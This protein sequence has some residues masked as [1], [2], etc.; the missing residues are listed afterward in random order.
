MRRQRALPVLACVAY[1]AQV[2]PR[3][4]L[5]AMMPILRLF[6]LAA[7]LV[8]PTTA[9]GRDYDAQNFDPAS[10]HGIRDVLAWIDQ[11]TLTEGQRNALIAEG[12]IKG[13]DWIELKYNSWQ[14]RYEFESPT[15][16]MQSTLR[17]FY[18]AEDAAQHLQRVEA[19]L[20]ESVS[21]V[22]GSVER[23]GSPGTPG[24]TGAYFAVRN[25]A[26]EGV[27]SLLAQQDGRRLYIVEVG[28]FGAFEDIDQADEFLEPKATVALSFEPDLGGKTPAEA[29]IEP[30]F[31]LLQKASNALI[32]LLALL[33]WL[34]RGIVALVNRLLPDRVRSGRTAG[35]VAV[36]MSV[37][38][39]TIG[40]LW[41]VIVELGPTFRALPPLEQGR[42]SG[43]A[44]MVGFFPALIV[45]L[46]VGIAAW[47][48][49]TP[50]VEQRPM[51]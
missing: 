20:R 6:V 14:R 18:G 47:L 32:V 31:D 15:V 12:S 40:A 39:A 13:S 23:L 4:G 2:A 51:G 19:D 3:H 28:G 38:A 16:R 46:P 10:L 43:S 27:F 11:E 49:R 34:V 44:L 24:R 5:S 26:G 17:V 1:R 42:M 36:L 45:L 29:R 22:G 21:R 41:F 33:Y 9:H 30:I 35:V 48:R 25:T 8:A 7:L 50:S 37:A